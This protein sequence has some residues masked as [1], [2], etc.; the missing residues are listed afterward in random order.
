MKVLD[1]LLSGGGGGGS[2]G[3]NILGGVNGMGVKVLGG[4]SKG[5]SL[6]KKKEILH[7]T[8]PKTYLFPPP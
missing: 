6:K 7:L 5:K 2:Y 4:N 1:G 8:Q 3:V